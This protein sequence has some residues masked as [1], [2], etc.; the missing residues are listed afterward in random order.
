MVGD[1]EGNPILSFT[2]YLSP[3]YMY[4]Y[5]YTLYILLITSFMILG[6]VSF[7]RIKKIL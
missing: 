7:E 1:E 6:I 2:F 4:I 3:T 5:M